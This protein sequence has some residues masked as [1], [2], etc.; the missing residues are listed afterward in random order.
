MAVSA[1][2]FGINQE[3]A[4]NL[5]T[6]ADPTGYMDVRGFVGPT[7]QPDAMAKQFFSPCPGPPA[8]VAQP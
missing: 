3:A 7:Y 2:M 4:G 6:G 5:S 1:G 8:A